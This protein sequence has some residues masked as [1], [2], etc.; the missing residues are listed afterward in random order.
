MD[1]VKEIMLIFNN[2]DIPQ[3]LKKY[4]E[5]VKTPKT[6]VFNINTKPFKEAHFAVFPEELCITPIKAGCPEYI[7]NKCGKPREKIIVSESI[8]TRPARKSKDLNDSIYGASQKRFMPKYK[9]EY[10]TD[11][12]C[13]AGFR[14]GVVLDPFFGAGTTGLVA[15]KLNRE[16]I[17]IELNPEYIEIAKARIAKEQ[18]Q[19]KMAL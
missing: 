3:K 12:N 2:K 18:A 1:Y 14:K 6:T 15:T 11:C 7:C 9:G 17:G 5:P 13:N 8:P 10:F 16:Y 19:G 4:F